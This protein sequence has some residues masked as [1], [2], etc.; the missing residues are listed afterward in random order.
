MS[1]NKATYGGKIL[2]KENY[3]MLM[4]EIKYDRNRWK[5]ISCSCI[6]R[7]NFVKMTI[8]QVLQY[9][10]FQYNPY[11]TSNGIFHRIRK[12]EITIHM[13]TQKTPIDKVILSKTIGA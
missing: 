1:E 13:E 8:I 7:I 11:H 6:R 5:S 3:K 12:K 9:N 2:Y 10:Q 4:K